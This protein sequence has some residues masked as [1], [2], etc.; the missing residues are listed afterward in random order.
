VTRRLRVAEQTSLA[1]LHAALQVA[2]GWSDEHLYTFQIG[3]TSRKGPSRTLMSLLP[4][5]V[6][7]LL[8]DVHYQKSA[9]LTGAIC[10]MASTNCSSNGQNMTRAFDRRPDYRSAVEKLVE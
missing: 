8:M 6:L 4:N 10:S 2:F 9:P 1:E 5:N 7:F 3:V